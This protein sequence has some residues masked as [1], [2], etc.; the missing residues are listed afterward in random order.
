MQSMPS[1]RRDLRRTQMEA[2]T[3][4]VSVVVAVVAG[5][6]EELDGPA[7]AVDALVQDPTTFLLI[8]V[9]VDDR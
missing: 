7:A 2:W 8:V 3:G 4:W 1:I 9:Q 5:A 6:A